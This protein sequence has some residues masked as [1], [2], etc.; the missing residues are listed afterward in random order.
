MVMLQRIN[1]MNFNRSSELLTSSVSFLLWYKRNSSDEE[2]LENNDIEDLH[3][4]F[5]Y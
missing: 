3:F 2:R 5:F 4:I 1:V